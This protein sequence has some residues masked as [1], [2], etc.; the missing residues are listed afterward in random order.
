MTTGGEPAPRHGR[1][2]TASRGAWLVVAAALF[3]VVATTVARRTPGGAGDPLPDLPPAV[4]APE[5][6]DPADPAAVVATGE[7]LWLQYCAACHD[8]RPGGTPTLGPALVSREYLAFAND[9]RIDSLLVHGVP[10]TA[11]L[12][13]GGRRGGMLRDTQVR[14]LTAYLRSKEASAPSVPGWKDGWRRA[15]KERPR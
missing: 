5:V 2:R 13:W 9:R 8:V 1:R 12:G 15:R 7:S 4:E 10:G 6:D 3:L 14:A 11:M